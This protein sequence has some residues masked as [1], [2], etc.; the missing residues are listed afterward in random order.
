M[1][2]I[3]IVHRVGISRI[4]LFVSLL[5]LAF[6]PVGRVHANTVTT[7]CPIGGTCTR[8]QASTSCQ[9]FVSSNK[10]QFPYVADNCTFNVNA[11]R[12]TAQLCKAQGLCTGVNELYGVFYYYSN[13]CPAGTEWFESEQNC[14]QPCLDRNPTTPPNYGY[15]TLS[16]AATSMCR[17]GCS[18]S[19]GDVLETRAASVCGT[20]S[21]A[22]QCTAMS[23]QVR[24]VWS[25]NGA[26]CSSQPSDPP[27]PKDDEPSCTPA[28]ANQTYCVM[29]NGNNC[30]TASSGRMICWA[31]SE[32]GSKTDGPVTQTSNNGNQSPNPP[33]GSEHTSTVTNTTSTSSNT[34]NTT[35]N[36]Y[37]TSS[38]ASAGSTNQGT[39]VGSD[40]KPTSG[41]T[42]TG[43]TGTGGDGDGQDDNTAS[44][45]GNCDTPPITSGDAILGMV[46]T[47]TWATRCAVEEG[48]AAKVTGDIGNCKASFSVEGTN[49]NAV[50]LRAMREQICGPG[51][52]ANAGDVFDAESTSA[53]SDANAEGDDP[54]DDEPNDPL[55]GSKVERDGNWLLDK[56]DAS[57]FLGGGACPPD[58]N[59]A[60]GSTSIKISF[61]PICTLLSAI[62]GLVVALAYIIAFRIMAS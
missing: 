10:G 18:F 55:A 53:A 17:S 20:G 5:L 32:Q 39:S 47:Q 41:G 19:R 6:L 23:S 25:Y 14:L 3:A 43:G 31:P 51:S 49:A 13:T 36:T 21:A 12:Y 60:V 29:P 61:G 37:T 15:W 2:F 54:P 58:T 45:G 16:S 27:P 46:A 48:N 50:K 22:G 11:A 38:G 44:G 24:A 4:F 34:S 52:V 57:G 42:G 56:L 9:S 33:P 40:G 30:Y 7:S 8:A 59:V 1:S 62:S 35:I 28:T 26:K